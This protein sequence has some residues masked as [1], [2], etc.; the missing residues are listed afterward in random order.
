MHSQDRLCPSFLR[1][2][3]DGIVNRLGDLVDLLIHIN[4]LPLEQ[5]VSH[6]GTFWTT[7]G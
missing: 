5:D 1:P 2:L 7:V 6:F 4:L 3:G